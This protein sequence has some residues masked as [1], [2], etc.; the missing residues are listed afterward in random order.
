MEVFMLCLGVGQ[1]LIMLWQLS[2]ARKSQGMSVA[3]APIS[4]RQ[5]FGYWPVVAMAVLAVAGWVPYLFHI[6]QS[7]VAMYV[8]AYG[9]GSDGCY[10]LIDGTK[11]V[12]YA[13]KYNLFVSCGFATPTV[14]QMQD[15]LISISNPFTINNTQIAIQAKYTDAMMDKA[16]AMAA[17]TPPEPAAI[18][19]QSFI[20]LKS[21][22][23][24]R[25][26]RLGDVKDFGGRL[27]RNCEPID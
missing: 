24:S 10:Q 27:L 13:S 17:K 22:D 5:R 11:L 6:G 8:P 19:T 26:K 18:W 15:G 16:K 1:T 21:T 7:E 25:V 4:S 20:L 2:I 23:V 9:T 14:D 3:E 12:K